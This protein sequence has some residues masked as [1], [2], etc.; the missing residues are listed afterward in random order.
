MIDMNAKNTDEITSI[1]GSEEIPLHNPVLATIPLV[2]SKRREEE[3]GEEAEY[4]GKPFVVIATLLVFL[5]FIMI[6]LQDTSSIHNQSNNNMHSSKCDVACSPFVF[7]SESPFQLGLHANSKRRVNDGVAQQQ[8]HQKRRRQQQQWKR[9]N[10]GRLL[11]GRE[12]A[13]TSPYTNV[14]GAGS[15]KSEE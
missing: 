6:I 13:K 9:D 5:S 2:E 7:H 14:Y 15:D 8:E 1:R 12:E 10:D 4:R 11:R 3:G